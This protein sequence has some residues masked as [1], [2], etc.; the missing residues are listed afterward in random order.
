MASVN[1]YQVYQQNS[2][3]MASRGELTA[4]LYDGA[5]KFLS[6]ANKAIEVKDI[7]GTHNFLIRAQEIINYLNNTLDTKYEVGQ[8]LASI[9][10]YILRRL[11]EAN[12]K[13]DK[14][15]IS[16]IIDLLKD[17]SSTWREAMVKAKGA[18]GGNDG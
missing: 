3:M 16:E 2:V 6:Q 13:K 9:Y 1:P 5:L 18:I 11:A 8:N 15:I 7:E 4:K 14:E 17:L 10:D 12:L